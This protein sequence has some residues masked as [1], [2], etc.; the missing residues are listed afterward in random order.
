[1]R[2]A[3]RL[4]D[5]GDDFRRGFLNSDDKKDRTEMTED[6]RDMKVSVMKFCFTGMIV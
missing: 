5:I 3:K 2:F 4:T 6:W 1:M